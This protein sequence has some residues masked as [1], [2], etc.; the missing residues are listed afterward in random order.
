MPPAFL[1][2]GGGGGGGRQLW[3]RGRGEGVSRTINFVG[4]FIFLSNKFNVIFQ[5]TDHAC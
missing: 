2:G 1:E 3:G 4:Y 5:T